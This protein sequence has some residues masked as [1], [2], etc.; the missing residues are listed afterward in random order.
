MREKNE[1]RGY[2]LHTPY[3]ILQ[4]RA[5]MVVKVI[6]FR[7]RDRSARLRLQHK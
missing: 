1:I 2:D 4:K 7:N 3:I 6:F 5:T